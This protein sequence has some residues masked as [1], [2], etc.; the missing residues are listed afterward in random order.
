MTEENLQQ[1]GG[2]PH[3]G[4]FSMVGAALGH[5]LVMMLRR[6]RI[7][8]AAVIVLLPVLIPLA[9]AFLSNKEFSEDGR[10]TFTMLAEQLHINVLAPLLALFFATMLVGEDAESQTIPY[11]L[12]RPMPRSAWLLGRFLAYLSVAASVLLVSLILTFAG[13]TSLDDLGFNAIHLKL[14]AHYAAV[15]LAALVGY[16]AVTVFLGATIKRP[17]VT[18]VVLLYGWQKLATTVPGVIDFFTIQKYTDA[19]LPALAAQ[20]DNVEVRSALLNFQKEVF[21]VSATRAGITLA[22]ISLVFLV[23]TV[24]AVRW[25]EYSAARAIGG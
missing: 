19:L 18:G 22:V 5:A 3:G 25:R 8:L 14:L 6:Q 11:V 15:A 10:K 1:T 12:T 16:G 7:I 2:Q 4:Y 21:L 13:C 17:I 20:Q 23:V 9:V 24:W